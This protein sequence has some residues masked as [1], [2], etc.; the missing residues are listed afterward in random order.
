MRARCH[1]F[2]VIILCRTKAKWAGGTTYAEN[3]EVRV[4]CVEAP[5]PFFPMVCGSTAAVFIGRVVLLY[6]SRSRRQPPRLPLFYK[7]KD[8]VA[9]FSL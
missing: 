8:L 4:A 2:L 1:H 3:R 6:C 9:L 7:L 5:L